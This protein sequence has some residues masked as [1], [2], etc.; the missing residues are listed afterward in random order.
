MVT[1]SNNKCK[2]RPILVE[3]TIFEFLKASYKLS[4]AT[5]VCFSRLNSF[6]FAFLTNI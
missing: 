3:N 4:N 5:I 2:D 1:F 6:S